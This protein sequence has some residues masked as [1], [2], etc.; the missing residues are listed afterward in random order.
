MRGGVAYSR[1]DALA[2]APPLWHCLHLPFQLLHYHLISVILQLF[3]CTTWRSFKISLLD[4]S[5]F[6]FFVLFCQIGCAEILSFC[7]PCC[8]E[9]RAEAICGRFSFLHPMAFFKRESTCKGRFFSSSIVLFYSWWGFSTVYTTESICNHCEL[10]GVFGSVG[11][12]RW[13]DE[14]LPWQRALPS[15]G[16]PRNGRYITR[17]KTSVSVR[18]LLLQ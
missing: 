8:W 16:A 11:R 9:T 17:L 10:A 15:S 12:G 4:F 1:G 6:C 7:L 5:L 18:A 3:C 2:E 14:G 13:G